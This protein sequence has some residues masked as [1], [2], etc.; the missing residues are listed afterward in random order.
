MARKR[1]TSRQ[2]SDSDDE[3]GELRSSA[4]VRVGLI[5][6]E[7][8][9]AR[10]V[11]Y[12]VVD[13]LAMFEG[14]IVLG[15]VEEVEQQTQQLKE[16]LS[17]ELASAVIISGAQFRWPN[18]TI[19]YTIDANLT[20]Q[21]RVTD[22]IAHWE[23][24][25]RFRFVE[26][27]AGNAATFP[28]WV[29]FRPGSG[30]SAAVGRRGGQ[31]F[32][33]LG[34]GCMTGNVIHEIGHVVGLWHEQSREDRDLFV[35]IHWD[36]IEPGFEHNFDQHITDGDDVGA[37]DY[38]SIMHYTRDAFSIDGDTITPVDPNATIGQRTALSAGDIAAANSFCRRPIWRI[39]RGGTTKWEQINTSA[40]RVPDLAFGDFT[41]D[42]KTDVFRANGTNWF[43]SEGGTGKWK[44]INTS[45]LRVPD[46]AFGDFTG[47]GKTDVFRANGTNWFISEGGTGKWKQ[48][49]TSALRVP[50]LAFGDFTGDGK[51]DVFRANGTNWFISEGGTGKWKQ[52]NTSALRVPDLAFGDFTGDGKTDVFRA[53]GTNWFISEGGTGKWKQINT[54]ALRV[55]DLAFGDFTGDGKTDVFRAN[56]TNWFISEGGT[57]KWKQINTSAL[58]VPDLAFGDF[59]GDGKTDVFSVGLG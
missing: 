18:C 45:A 22:A 38:G 28:D 51:T 5:A 10:A 36:R 19:P 9:A 11:R 13:G 48:I 16:V 17:G 3:R 39:S 55:P 40:L 6:L 47:D 21:Q 58:R 29:T 52:I 31:Q 37:Y 42:G 27:T 34:T 41:G 30:C 53:N 25:T 46:L 50:D 1:N 12:A 56:G 44:Q 20:S 24:N 2:A 35:T 54:S 7:S 43:I 59:T 57:G 32:V 23:T 49:N 14:D 4:D 15:T 26:R 8:A 33:N